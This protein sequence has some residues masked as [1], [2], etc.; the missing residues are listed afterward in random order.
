MLDTEKRTCP[1]CNVMA[2]LAEMVST[3]AGRP[4]MVRVRM[5]CAECGHEWTVE[6]IDRRVTVRPPKAN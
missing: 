1:A 4:N 6:F 3:I 2:G 5:V